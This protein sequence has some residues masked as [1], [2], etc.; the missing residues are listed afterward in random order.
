MVDWAEAQHKDSIKE[1]PTLS[2]IELA[3]V[4]GNRSACIQQFASLSAVEND[5]AVRMASAACDFDYRLACDY[6]GRQTPGVYNGFELD[7]DE[8]FKSAEKECYRVHFSDCLPYYIVLKNNFRDINL[9][10]YLKTYTLLGHEQNFCHD[11]SLPSLEAI[12]FCFS[13]ANNVWRYGDG[14]YWGSHHIRESHERACEL[15]KTL[16]RAPLQYYDSCLQASAIILSEKPELRAWFDV[17]R[18]RHDTRRAQHYKDLLRR[19]GEYAALA[20]DVGEIED[21]CYIKMRYY[22]DIPDEF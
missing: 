17:L 8:V 13:Y 16:E 7:L 21:A 15:L 10:F 5:K 20:C 22:E 4:E 2:K 1:I 19:A 12:E 18:A 11:S 9:P 6:I 14:G 3:C